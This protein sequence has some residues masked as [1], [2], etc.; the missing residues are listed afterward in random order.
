MADTL[1]PLWVPPSAS[2]LPPRVDEE[3]NVYVGFAGV[4]EFEAFLELINKGSVTERGIE[5]HPELP[6]V[7]VLINYAPRYAGNGV[8]AIELLTT[9]LDRCDDGLVCA[10]HPWLPPRHPVGVDQP[11]TDGAQ[12]ARCKGKPAPCDAP[13]HGFEAPPADRPGEADGSA[14]ETEHPSD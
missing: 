9:I 12:H 13:R 1:T 7:A 11:L 8:A 5:E 14:A 10:R 3:G 6:G 2:L 4:E